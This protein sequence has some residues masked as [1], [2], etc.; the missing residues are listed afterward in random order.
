[1]SSFTNK[2]YLDSVTVSSV[3]VLLCKITIPLNSTSEEGPRG[4]HVS[5]SSSN[6]TIRF[7]IGK[8]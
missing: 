5:N 1:M 2:Q 7:E 8:Q 4:K 6:V 3:R